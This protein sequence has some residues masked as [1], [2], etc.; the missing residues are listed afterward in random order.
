VADLSIE[1]C[2]INFKNPVVVAAATPTKDAKWM[3]KGIE[4]GAG[5]IVTKTVTTE[6]LLQRYVRPR[7]TVLHK[8]GWPDVFSNYSCEFLATYEP[9]EWMN[10]IRVAKKYA[11]NHNCVLIGSI[12]GTSIE[13]WEKLA[14]M[15]ESADIDMIEVNFGCPHPRETERKQGAELGRDVETA[16]KV[17]RAVTKAVDIPVFAKLTPEAVD[18]VN[19]ARA[20]VK[21]GASGVTIINRYPAL[22]IDINTGRP[23]LH[24]T[25]A[26]VGGPWMRPIT[27]KWI[28][29]VAQA[30]DAPISATNGVWTYKDVVKCIMCGASTVQTCTALMYSRKGYGQLKD[31]IGGLSNFMDEKGY[32]FITDFKGITPPQITNWVKVDR[33]SRIFSII[34]EDRCTGCKLCGNWCFYDAISFG[35]NNIAIIDKSKC[36]GCGLCVSLCPRDAIRMSEK[37]YLGDYS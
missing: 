18:V 36:D 24:G 25:F 14:M 23:L 5:G 20:V 9:E 21:A 27:L 31:L 22:D 11:N 13:V 8:K 26:G 30:I 15:I 1:V 29:K 12:S 6:K 37:V 35:D 33:E 7:F 34:D 2:G 19:A 17:T 3:K 10:E 28:A 32:R 16:S 4:L